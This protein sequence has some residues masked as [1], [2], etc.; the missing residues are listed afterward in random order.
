MSLA[1]HG[2]VLATS[3][4]KPGYW[5]TGTRTFYD[6]ANIPTDEKVNAVKVI[7]RHCR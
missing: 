5:D 7:T 3:D 1:T 2:N 6:L 4:V